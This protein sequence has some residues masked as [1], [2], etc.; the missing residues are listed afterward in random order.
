MLFQIA[1][2]YL[3]RASAFWILDF[4]DLLLMEHRLVVLRPARGVGEVVE[5]EDNVLSAIARVG[6]S[7]AVEANARFALLFCEIQRVGLAVE[8]DRE[9]PQVVVGL[10]IINNL[11]GMGFPVALEGDLPLLN[12]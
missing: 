2:A 11:E 4:D 3:K 12:L 10:G 5:I 8:S 1:V 9:A 6:H 7:E